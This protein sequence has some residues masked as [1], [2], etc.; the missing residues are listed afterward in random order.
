VFSNKL[1]YSN[2]EITINKKKERKTYVK[3]IINGCQGSANQ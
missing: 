3:L 1:K 2:L